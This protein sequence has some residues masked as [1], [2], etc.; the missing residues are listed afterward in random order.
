MA[1][2]DAA[3]KLEP[4][5]PDAMAGKADELAAAGDFEGAVKLYDAAVKAEPEELGFHL[6]RGIMLYR[7]GRRA[8][9]EKLLAE[10]RPKLTTSSGFNRLCW[11]KATAG[12]LLES[13]LLDCKEA[14]RL[15]PSDHM[16]GDSLGLVLLRLGKLDEAIDQYTRAIAGMGAAASYMGRAIAFARK[17][18]KARAEAD[19]AKALELEPEAEAQFASYGVKL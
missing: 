19:R 5:N 4:Q 15:A 11:A 3:L 9:G 14:L 6:H 1:D 13:A 17:G 2:Y 8:E 7:A 12:I 18:D 16:A 10:Q